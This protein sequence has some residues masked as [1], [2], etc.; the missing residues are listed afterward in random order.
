MTRW[1]ILGGPWYEAEWQ[2]ALDAVDAARPY[3][4]VL[5]RLQQLLLLLRLFRRSTRFRCDGD[6]VCVRG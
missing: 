4:R 1:A 5:L 6:N 2:A 3:L